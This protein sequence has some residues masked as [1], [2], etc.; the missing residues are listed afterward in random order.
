VDDSDVDIRH[1]AVVVEVPAVPISA[2][3]A[4]T[5][6]PEA[7]VHSAIEADVRPPITVIKDEEKAIPTPIS[8]CP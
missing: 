2:P 6:I 1:G 8:R 5:R 3:I 4:A 7:V